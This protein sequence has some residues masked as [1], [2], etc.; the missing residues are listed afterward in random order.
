VLVPFRH[1]ALVVPFGEDGCERR[2]LN[3]HNYR[4]MR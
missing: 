4:Q 3:V 1:M 2:L